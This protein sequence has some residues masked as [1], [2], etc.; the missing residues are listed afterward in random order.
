MEKYFC[1][2]CGRVLDDSEVNVFW[3]DSLD[4]IYVSCKYCGSDCFDYDEDDVEDK[5]NDEDENEEQ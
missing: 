2:C 5:D 4:E 1:D 3:D